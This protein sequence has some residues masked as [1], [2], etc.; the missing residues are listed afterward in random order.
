VLAPACVGLGTN[1]CEVVSAAAKEKF[2]ASATAIEAVVP[3]S[4]D[5]D[6]EEN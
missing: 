1:I 2:S 3:N 5:V 4:E 6:D